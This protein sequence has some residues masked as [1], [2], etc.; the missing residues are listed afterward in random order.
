[1]I[2]RFRANVDAEEGPV[3]RCRACFRTR[4]PMRKL[5]CALPGAGMILEWSRRQAPTFAGQC[6]MYAKVAKRAPLSRSGCGL[7]VNASQGARP[8]QNE[9]VLVTLNRRGFWYTKR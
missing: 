5:T 2:L 3:P 6:A 9:N 1:M 4:Q 8:L 7:P